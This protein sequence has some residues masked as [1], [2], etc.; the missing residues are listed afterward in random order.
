M[1]TNEE[2]PDLAVPEVVPNVE[3]GTSTRLHWI[4]GGLIL[5]SGI[6][7]GFGVAMLWRGTQRH[8]PPKADE[9]AR[10]LG[11]KYALTNEQVSAVEKIFRV[12]HLEMG[13]LREKMH[14]QRKAQIEKLKREIKEVLTAE[15]YVRWNKDFEEHHK[16]RRRFGR[17]RH[18]PPPHQPH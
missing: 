6:G 1:S 9:I 2:S 17:R 15:Q 16:R 11:Q 3:G 7:I 14:E 5:A 13:E 10:Q 18:R 8:L 12:R 4:L